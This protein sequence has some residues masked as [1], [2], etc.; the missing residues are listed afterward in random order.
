[1]KAF[2]RHALRPQGPDVSAWRTLVRYGMS[3]GSYRVLLLV[4]ALM[5]V[6]A[7][8]NPTIRYDRMVFDLDKV[9]DY[10]V[11]EEEQSWKDKGRMLARLGDLEGAVEAFTSYVEERPE[12]YYGFNALAICYKKQGDHRKAM[13]NFERALEFA[14]TP[15]E[16]AKILANIGNLYKTWGKPQVALGYYKEAAKESDGQP[17]HLILVSRAYMALDQSDR[18]KKVLEQIEHSDKPIE[19]PDNVDDPGLASYLMAVTYLAL[20]KAEPDKVIRYLEDAVKADPDRFVLQIE[21]D[22]NREQ[23]LLYTLKGDPT[24]TAMLEKYQDRMM[25]LVRQTR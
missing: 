6:G 2:T 10:E 7:C 9:F 4:G 5:F 20:G 17:Y 3:M 12:D 25:P 19:D 11:T 18:A 16:R 13:T 21:R 14:Q 15:D 1:M 8:T 22:M 24:L 23:S